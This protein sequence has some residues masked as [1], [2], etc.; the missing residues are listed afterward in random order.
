MI[1]M[2]TTKEDKQKFDN[3]TKETIYE[4]YLLEV[5]ARLT[6]NKEVNR[7]NRRLAEIRFMAAGVRD[8]IGCN[9]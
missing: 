1:G 2:F 3:W 9:K 4:A 6:L 5:E 8:T 7:L